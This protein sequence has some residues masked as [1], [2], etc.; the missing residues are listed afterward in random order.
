MTS[1]S[2]KASVALAG[3]HVAAIALG[4]AALATDAQPS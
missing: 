4:A 1:I 2:Q 3:L